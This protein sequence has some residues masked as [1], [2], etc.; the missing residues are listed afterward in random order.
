MNRLPLPRLRLIQVAGLAAV[1]L[2]AAGTAVAVAEPKSGV[3]GLSSTVNQLPIVGGLAKSTGVGKAL[4]DVSAAAP[5]LPNLTGKP[6]KGK[7][8]PLTS[9]LPLQSL[10]TDGL[11]ID[12]LPLNG[13]KVN[14]LGLT[15]PMALVNGLTSGGLGNGV[16]G[17]GKPAT[18]SAKKPSSRAAAL[19]VPGGDLTGGLLRNLPL[20]GG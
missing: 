3:T 4:P 16:P 15:D 17:L 8:K 5:S 6:A 14:S 18:S 7:A 19:P 12:K 10:P 13:L 20:L 9:A 11:P 2:I 1:A